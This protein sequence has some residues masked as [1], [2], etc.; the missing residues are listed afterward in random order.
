MGTNIYFNNNDCDSDL[1]AAI[2]A[3]V[4]LITSIF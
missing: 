1:V 4:D 2:K 3:E